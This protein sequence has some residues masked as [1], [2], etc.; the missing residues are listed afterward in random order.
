M[1]KEDA[2]EKTLASKIRAT[3]MAVCSELYKDTFQNNS[4]WQ[5]LNL[6][7]APEIKNESDK[8][9]GEY[10]INILKEKNGKVVNISKEVITIK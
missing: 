9:K 10:I 7:K 2:K 1:D 4:Y 5:K 8:V 6:G 3:F